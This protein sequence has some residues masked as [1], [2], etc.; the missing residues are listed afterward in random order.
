[1]LRIREANI[2][3]Q[4]PAVIYHQGLTTLSKEGKRS[5]FRKSKDQSAVDEKATSIEF[6]VLTLE[7]DGMP[8]FPETFGSC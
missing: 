7:G 6:G 1:M 8:P 5:S 2:G 4:T 3:I